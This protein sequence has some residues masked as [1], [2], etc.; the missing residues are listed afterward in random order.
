MTAKL[1]ISFKDSLMGA[2][3]GLRYRILANDQ[4]IDNA[5]IPNGRDA[6]ITYDFN[7]E[8]GQVI[9]T[10]S[11]GGQTTLP[12]C[13]VYSILIHLLDEQQQVEKI[14]GA[15]LLP[16]GKQ[17]TVVAISPW[18]KIPLNK[19]SNE[20]LSGDFFDVE[21]NIKNEKNRVENV[22]IRIKDLPRKIVLTALKYRNSKKWAKNVATTSATHPKLNK[23]IVFKAGDHKCNLFVHDVLT[24][25]GIS[26]P[27]IEHGKAKYIPWHIAGLSPPTAAE[28]EDTERLTANWSSE[29]MPMPGDV[30]AY[31]RWSPNASGHVGIIV[32]DGVTVSADVDMIVVNDVG[33]RIKHNRKP[34]LNDKD[35][36]V[37]RRYKG[38][39][40]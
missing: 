14:L 27:W 29:L 19:A 11:N 12:K 35:F 39:A 26:V 30:G 7:D 23:N 38:I 9:V 17:L 2:P 1:I 15:G 20:K 32:C 13:D 3:V 6:A 34:G 25:A 33:F 4:P 10:S 22:K 40:Q 5:V 36:T 8:A 28:W 24:E 16:N 37:F 31:G 21:Y 18:T